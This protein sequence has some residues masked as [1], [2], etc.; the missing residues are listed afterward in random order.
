MK[1]NNI[2]EKIEGC[3][4]DWDLKG[5]QSNLELLKRKGDAAEMAHQLAFYFSKNYTTFNADGTAKFIEVAIR[6]WPE[7]ATV[8]FPENAFFKLSIITGSPELFEC[9]IEETVDPMLNERSQ[10]DRI[11]AFYDLLQVAEKLNSTLLRKAER[12]R[13]GMHFNGAFGRHEAKENVVLINSED[14]SII[15][16]VVEKYNALVGRLDII[17][18]LQEKVKEA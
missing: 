14:Y 17:K 10:E 7:I 1:N 3:I 4:F 18:R 9:Y 13:K 16:E 2:I 6:S 11:D 15:D 12:V 8:Y 5:F